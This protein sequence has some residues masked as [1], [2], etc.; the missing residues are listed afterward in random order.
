MNHWRETPGVQSN[1]QLCENHQS[2]AARFFLFLMVLGG[3]W[4]IFPLHCSCFIIDGVALIFNFEF[5]SSLWFI[6]DN[7]YWS[8]LSYFP[9]RRNKEWQANI[10]FEILVTPV[11]FI[12]FTT[13]PKR[14][15]SG[16]NYIN[17]VCHYIF[18]LWSDFLTHLMDS[19][20]VREASEKTLVFIVC[21]HEEVEVFLGLRKEKRHGG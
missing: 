10:S 4:Y 20:G 7:F 15:P 5:L 19:D 3:E 16:P 11:S 21:L 6:Y 2:L 1:L 18:P 14:T 17:R 13:P 8:V 12:H 9:F